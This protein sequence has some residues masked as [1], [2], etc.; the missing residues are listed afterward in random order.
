MYRPPDQ[1]TAFGGQQDQIG[2]LYLAALCGGKAKL[3]A[4]RRVDARFDGLVVGKQAFQRFGDVF[5]VGLG[6][7]MQKCLDG[8]VR[9]DDVRCDDAVLGDAIEHAGLSCVSAFVGEALCNVKQ[10]DLVW[11][12]VGEVKV[13]A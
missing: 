13:F 6:S 11:L 7:I 4:D 8:M 12:R 5:A 1:I 2:A 10:V 3:F 9:G